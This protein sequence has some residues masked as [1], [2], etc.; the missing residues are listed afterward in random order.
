MLTIWSML[1]VIERGLLM[2]GTIFFVNEW[3]NLKQL[4]SPIVT[5]DAQWP[6]VIF[7][8]ERGTPNGM[9]QLTPYPDGFFQL[10][11]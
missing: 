4:M 3:S 5:M 11:V 2:I 1:T 10:M 6:E 7:H 8:G 9:A